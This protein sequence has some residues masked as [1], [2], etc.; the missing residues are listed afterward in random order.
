MTV[1]VAQKNLPCAIRALFPRAEF[2]AD[3]FQMRLPR[4]ET[5]YAQ[6][7][8][9][10]GIDGQKR[11]V[12]ADEMQLLIRAQPEPRARIIERRTRNR[13]QPQNVAIK[14]AAPFQVRYVDGNVIKLVNF[15]GLQRV[16]R[17]N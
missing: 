15:Q 6:C 14:C 7:E 13:F 4:R 12:P 2:R 10:V 3:L 16:V 8:M 9:I 17:L 1:R 11:L 5:V